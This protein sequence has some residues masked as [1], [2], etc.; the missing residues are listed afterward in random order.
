MPRPRENLALS[1]GLFA[2]FGA[3]LHEDFAE[4]VL[5]G[6]GSS[7]A[8]VEVGRGVFDEFFVAGRQKHFAQGFMGLELFADGLQHDLIAEGIPIGENGK[9]AGTA[10]LFGVFGSVGA[11][12]ALA[13]G[14]VLELLGLKEVFDSG[15]PG[16]FQ[17]DAV[18][19]EIGKLEVVH[20][21]GIKIDWHDGEEEV[22]W[23]VENRN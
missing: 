21:L 10:Q 13:V 1:G 20:C 7:V 9:R 5:A 2:Q 12:D 17:L 18:R 23:G 11:A 16:V 19:G 3:D 15:P 4:L 6:S 22:T 14:F 8:P